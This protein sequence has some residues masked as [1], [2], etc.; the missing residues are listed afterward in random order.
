MIKS[1]A[2]YFAWVVS[3]V[4]TG[5]SLFLSEVMDFMPCTLCWYQRILM[6]PLVLLLGRAAY[7]NDRGI[8]GYALPLSIIGA[9]F[10]L[11]HYL[12]QQIPALAKVLPCTQGI[13]CNQDYLDWFGGVVTIPFLALIAFILITIF[14]IAGRSAQQ[15]TA[16]EE[17]A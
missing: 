8:I 12:E 16:E 13:P 4:A 7:R 1:Y 9:G 14:L 11:Y 2:L 17:E 6:Y 3:L 5:G 10:S 15:V